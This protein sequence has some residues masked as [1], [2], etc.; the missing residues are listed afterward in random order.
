MQNNIRLSLPQHPYPP[1]SPKQCQD[2][3]TWQ[4][5]AQEH[6][7]AISLLVTLPNPSAEQ[8]DAGSS[9]CGT[10]ELHCRALSEPGRA[11]G[12]CFIISAICLFALPSSA[13]PGYAHRLL[14]VLQKLCRVS[15][16]KPQAGTKI[17]RGKAG[18]GGGGEENQNLIK[19][20]FASGPQKIYKFI[21]H[22]VNALSGCYARL[23]TSPTRRAIKH[24]HRA[25]QLPP[26]TSTLQHQATLS[27]L[28]SP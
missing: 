19:T 11:A 3:S 7:L 23:P 4:M 20:T 26:S 6:S 17:G 24:K 27:S 16:N 10:L 8:R 5:R 21:N 2:L 13:P 9:Y 28:S 25:R 18:K 1:G 12:G 15:V 22:L 14:P